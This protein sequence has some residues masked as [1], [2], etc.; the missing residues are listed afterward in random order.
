[1]TKS[2][3]LEKTTDQLP[4]TADEELRRAMMEGSG[5]G[6]SAASEDNLVPLAYLLQAQS[7]QVMKGDPARIEGAE[8]G[9]IWLRN[10]PSPIIKGDLGFLFQPCYMYREL[11]EWLPQRGGFAGRFDISL[12]PFDAKGNIDIHGK[13]MGELADVRAVRDTES[14][15]ERYNFLRKDSNNEIVD[16]RYWVGIIENNGLVQPYILPLASTGHS[17][18][19]QLNTSIRSLIASGVVGNAYSTF[20]RIKTAF[21]TNA[22]GSWYQYVVGGLE[23]KAQKLEEVQRG[24]ALFEAFSTG[25]KVA[26]TPDAEDAPT[27]SSGGTFDNRE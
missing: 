3:A 21:N 12:A 20:W 1:M 24:R 2:Q 26:A 23:R 6:T 11:V 22:S 7:P 9:D 13:W 27:K 14:E 4:A 18:A 17:F 8:A 5:A 19:K 15:R 10:S 25:L 16:T